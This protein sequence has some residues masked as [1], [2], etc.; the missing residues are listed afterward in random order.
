[1]VAGP[2]LV[3]RTGNH[4]L[5][6]KRR[7]E[8][9]RRP[10]PELLPVR[11][12]LYRFFPLLTSS[13]TLAP[14]ASFLPALGFGETTRPFFTLAEK[15]LVTLPTE[16]CARLIAR[17]AARTVL[18]FTLGTTHRALKVALTERASDMVRVQFL[19]V[20]EQAPDQPANLERAEATAVSV[21]AVPCPK[22]CAQ[23]EPQM[24]PAGLE[25][26]VPAPF[27]AL[28]SVSVLSLSNLAVAVWSAPIVSV[29]GPVP[30]Q[31]PDQPAK[32]DPAEGV[33]VSVTAVPCV[34]ACAQVKPQL[35]PAGLELIVP[36]PLPA[37]ARAS[38]LSLS[39]VAVAVW[40]AFIER[41]QLPLPEQS[42]DQPVKD[43]PG[44]AVAVSAT[45]P[46]AKDAEQVEPQLIPSGL[47]VTEPEP[48][49]VL[50]TVSVLL[51]R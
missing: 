50:A 9:R 18:P 15:T 45:G 27:P 19:P 26:T 20:P 29:Q 39:N 33:A 30:E 25:L 48:L 1:M 34:K 12:L 16:Q 10:S 36:L 38:V 13:L 44:E 32:D 40:S 28:V 14:G 23:V 31:A 6:R 43:D 11:R 35:I 8:A 49:P 37:F 46:T 42:P 51:F 5:S 2:R 7:R 21:T 41:V 24:I 47:D 17:L 4:T 3:R 22:A